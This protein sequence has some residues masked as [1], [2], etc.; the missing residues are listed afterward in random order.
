MLVS[1][2]RI[3]KKSFAASIGALALASTVPS[4]GALVAFKPTQSNL[5]TNPVVGMSQTDNDYVLTSDGGT[6][7]LDKAF[8]T[9]NAE[10]GLFTNFTNTQDAASLDKNTMYQ[11]GTNDGIYKIDMVTGDIQNI[12]SLSNLSAGAGAFGLGAVDNSIYSFALNGSNEAVMT[13]FN[14]DTGANLGTTNFGDL[15]SY[16]TLTG[17]EAYKTAAGH[18][19]FLLTTKDDP[20]DSANNYILDFNSDGSFT[21]NGLTIAGSNLEDITYK[22][23]IIAVGQDNGSVADNGRVQVGAY[24]GTAIPEPGAFGLGA[25]L[26]ALGAAATRRPR[27]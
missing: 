23:G 3:P 21:G 8:S 20:N 9:D 27:K 10:V 22:D 7:S 19:G 4:Q 14:A 24:T 6:F 26:L 16:G 13:H 15:S 1:K 11:L 17:A 5:V 12:G 2:M 25:G 18:I